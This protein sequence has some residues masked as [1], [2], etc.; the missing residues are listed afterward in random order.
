MFVPDKPK[1]FAEAYRV[2]KPGGVFLFTTWD[3]LE[4]NAASYTSRSLAKKY[5]EE[6]LP[7][8]YNLATSMSDEAVIT[9]L[10]QDAGFSKISIEKV[11]LFS[12][13]P[14]AK[15]AANG[16]VEGGFIYKEIK[17]RNPAWIDEIKIKVEKELAEKFGAAPMIAPISAV[18]S[19]AW[20]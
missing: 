9:P 10:L 1:A 20:K 11:K 3:K 2:L 14:S 15:E 16:L 6:P 4:N 13:C 8:S 18:I 17:K 5:L 7:E 19:Q 12:V